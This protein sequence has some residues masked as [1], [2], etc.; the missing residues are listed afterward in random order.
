MLN[1]ILTV[2]AIANTT[3]TDCAKFDMKLAN[4]GRYCIVAKLEN[5]STQ[6]SLFDRVSQV[7]QSDAILED[8]NQ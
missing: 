5:D 3:A 6:V 1:L 8:L 2:I 7:Y 4:N